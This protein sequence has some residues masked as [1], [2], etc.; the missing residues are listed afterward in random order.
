LDPERNR[1]VDIGTE[2]KIRP[3]VQGDVG[4]VQVGAPAIIGGDKM[5]RRSQLARYVTGRGDVA[6][7]YHASDLDE[8]NP[9]AIVAATGDIGQAVVEWQ[10]QHQAGNRWGA[11]WRC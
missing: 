6:D 1:E 8:V 2:M 3:V 9:S 7:C 11:G 10:V 5:Q 4:A